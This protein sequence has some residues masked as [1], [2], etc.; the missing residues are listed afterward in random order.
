[1]TENAVN[2][3]VIKVPVPSVLS[4]ENAIKEEQDYNRRSREAQLDRFVK[5]TRQ[6]EEYAKKAFILSVV[7]LSLVFVIVLLQGFRLELFVGIISVAFK[8]S[9]A[10]LVTLI[11]STTANVLGLSVIVYKFIFRY[12]D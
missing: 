6:R 12:T 8:L 10:V 5:E 3:D 7:W 1:M 11:G 4:D 9:D 2:L